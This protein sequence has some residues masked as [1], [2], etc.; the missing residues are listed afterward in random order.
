M[1]FRVCCEAMDSSGNPSSTPRCQAPPLPQGPPH[2]THLHGVCA[3]SGAAIEI[4]FT[5]T[6]PARVAYTA[7]ALGHGGTAPEASAVR[8]SAVIRGALGAASDWVASGQAFTRSSRAGSPTAHAALTTCPIRPAAAVVAVYAVVDGATGRSSPVTRMDVNVTAVCSNEARAAAQ[9]KECDAQD[10]LRHLKP[11][12]T[13]P[14]DALVFPAGRP[15]L[16]SAAADSA[17]PGGTLEVLQDVFVIGGARA[18]TSRVTV[19]AAPEARG[20]GIPV[21]LTDAT[22][23]ALHV[24]PAAAQPGR[25]SAAILTPHLHL[26]PRLPVAHSDPPANT[27][28]A[29][30]P[31][32]EAAVPYLEFAFSLRDSDGNQVGSGGPVGGVSRGGSGVEHRVRVVPALVDGGGVMTRL[33]GCVVSGADGRHGWGR[34]RAAVPHGRFPAAGGRP[35]WTYAALELQVRCSR[36]HC[37]PS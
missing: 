7:I 3:A 18:A 14:P 33:G 24:S 23:A 15:I 9:A 20:R 28:E 36:Y 29:R 37:D 22:P 26:E 2:I 21:S 10:F 12:L 32:T 8:P 19:T 4:S 27:T 16:S 17:A 30:G 11:R 1:P 31:L 6:R 13:P 34:C 5:T 35:V 25:I